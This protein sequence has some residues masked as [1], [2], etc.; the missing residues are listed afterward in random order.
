METAK[1]FI[2]ATPVTKTDRT[3]T[4]RCFSAGLQRRRRSTDT[5]VR[6]VTIPM[7]SHMTHTLT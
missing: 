1:Q 4:N 6:H 7:N 3:A 5:S 2:A